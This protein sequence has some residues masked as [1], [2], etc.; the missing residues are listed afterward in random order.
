MN[1][2]DK[3]IGKHLVEAFGY[4][5]NPWEMKGSKVNT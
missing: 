3:T 5:D 4:G 1:N 2:T